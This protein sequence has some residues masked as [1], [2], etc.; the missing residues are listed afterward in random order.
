MSTLQDQ[1]EVNQRRSTEPFLARDPRSVWARATEMRDLIY[2]AVAVTC[3][4]L[5]MKTLVNRSSDFSYPAWVSLE[6]WLVTDVPDAVQRR[7]CVFAIR[8]MPYSRF[9]FEITI[10]CERDGERGSYG[11]Y[12]PEVAKCVPEWVKYILDKGQRPDTIR[13]RIRKFSWQFWYSKNVVVRLSPDLLALV[14]NISIVAA[15]VFGLSA[16]KLPE[17]FWL[18]IAV[19]AIGGAAAGYVSLWKLGRVRINSSQRQLFWQT[20]LS[21]HLVAR[22]RPNTLNLAANIS[23]ITAVVSFLYSIDFLDSVGLP[24][25]FV[26]LGI[27][28]ACLAVRWRRREVVIN[29]GRPIAEPRKLRVVDNWQVMVTDLGDKWAS[30]RE[31][32]IDR[33]NEGPNSNIQWREERIS[34]LTPDRKQEREQLVLSQGRGI[35]F[36]HVYPYGKDL[37]IGW[38]SHVNYGRWDEVEL[39]RG[40]DSELK[41]PAIV[42][43]VVPG[44]ARI[45]E[46]DLIDLNS[47]TEWVHSRVVDIVSLAVEEYKI[48][49]EIDYKINRSPRESL[50]RDQDTRAA[51]HVADRDIIVDRPKN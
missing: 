27:A 49:Q 2:D 48:D 7:F 33:F 36:C 28:L 30:V 31:Q 21:K 46:Y 11:P 22:L 42:N 1:G 18:L 24:I 9:E 16:V 44:V 20:W 5:R 43:T 38:D 51:G 13:F 26:S 40:F 4:E 8:P 25:A 3:K 37:F 17:S 35:V 34:Y 15:T 19:I 32:L 39:A 45:N 12:E 10:N 23:A 14:A 29:P 41:K 47:L 6:A 50:L